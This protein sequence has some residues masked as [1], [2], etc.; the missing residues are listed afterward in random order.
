MLAFA[1]KETAIWISYSSRADTEVLY[2][3]DVDENV[4]QQRVKEVAARQGREPKYVQDLRRLLEDKAVD[5]VTTA[6]PNHWHALVAIWAIQAGKDV[7]VE[8]PVS[9][10][11]S[12]GRRIVDAARKIRPYVPDRHAMPLD[13]RFDRRDRVRSLG[14]IGDVKIARGLCY[15]WRPSI[16]P[17]GDYP[18]PARVNYDLWSGPAAGQAADAREA[19]LR[20]AL[21]LGLRQ[22]RPGEPGHPS[23]GPGPLGTGRQDAQHRS[24][25]LRRPAW[26]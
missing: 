3:C 6:T 18:I 7:Y 11:V 19:T 5:I 17:K 22:R 20:L 8:K 26:L 14:K 23:N 24:R 25:Q 15:K 21:D 9:H 10:N 16:G 4:G 13:E 12:E 2:V 1:D